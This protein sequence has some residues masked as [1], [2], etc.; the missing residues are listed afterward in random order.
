LE[1]SNKE[2]NFEEQAVYV[3]HGVQSQIGYILTL[4]AGWDSRHHGGD[5]GFSI[6]V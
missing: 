6:L 1:L 2:A 5:L 3:G 4:E